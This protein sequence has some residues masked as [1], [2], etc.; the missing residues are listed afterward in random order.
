M[1]VDVRRRARAA[2]RGTPSAPTRRARRRRRRRCSP[3]SGPRTR[4]A[5]RSVEVVGVLHDVAS[6][7]RLSAQEDGDR[8][9]V[10]LAEAVR[11]RARG[12]CRAMV[13][14]W[15]IGAP[16][17]SPSPVI[18]SRSFATRSRLNADRRVVGVLVGLRACTARTARRRR[19]S[20]RP[21]R[22]S[23]RSTPGSLGE[24]E[25]LGQRDV[26][27]VDEVVDRELRRRT[28]AAAADVDHARRP[29]RRAPARTRS[30]SCGI[31]PRP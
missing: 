10:A 16:T 18:S 4:R 5:C 26:Q 2:R 15:R 24:D 25:R 1:R 12:R 6:S 9:E 29:A 13:V 17:R 11:D 22:R 27:P 7:G 30:S 31:A 8:A 14:A 23:S 3:C 20:R 21:R 28:R 19:R